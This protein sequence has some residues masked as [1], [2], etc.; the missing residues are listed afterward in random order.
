[1]LAA[2]LLGI[3]LARPADRLPARGAVLGPGRRRRLVVVWWAFLAYQGAWLAPRAHYTEL[4]EIGER[5]DGEG[6]ALGTEVSVYGPRHF[7]RDLTPRARA[8][9]A[10]P[11]CCSRDGGRARSG[12]PSTS[13]KIRSDQLDPYN[14]LVIRRGPP[15]SRP[16]AEFSARL[17]RRALRSLEARTEAPGTLVEHLPLGDRTGRRRGPGLR[18]RSRRLA[19]GCRRRRL[20]GRGPGR[21]ADRGRVRRRRRCPPAGHAV[22]PTPSRR[23]GAGSDQRRDRRARRR[24]RALARRAR[25]S[26]RL[27]IR[28]DGEKVASERGVAQQRRRARAARPRVD[29][30]PGTHQLEVEYYGARASGR[31]APRS[32]YAVGPLEL[33]HAAGRRPRAG[34]RSRRPNTGSSAAERWDWVEAC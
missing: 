1:M 19:P 9:A 6:P 14:L 31:A 16:P 21:H 32:P 23:A 10:A 26:A 28:I 25:S 34:Q 12:V 18:R 7:L 8:T 3:V 11:R 15:T 29:A 5:F 30:V 4:E 20:A 13:T 33:P 27:D 17:Q 22:S 24:I 2:A